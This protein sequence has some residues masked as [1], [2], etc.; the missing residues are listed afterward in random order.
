MKKLLLSLALTFIAAASGLAADYADIS[1][2]DLK[3]LIKEG[4]VVV[5]DVN[6]TRS[7]S[8]GHIPGALDFRAHEDE[9]AEILKDT[10]KDTLV[11]AYCGGPSCEAY[12]AGAEAVE[13]MGFKNVKHL[14]AGI[15]GWIGAGEETE[16][17]AKKE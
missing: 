4:K 17:D 3:K 1:V 7:Y 10:D 12:I 14:S 16:Q 11:V 5:L 15:S 13:K 6:G 2:A 9:L 8:K